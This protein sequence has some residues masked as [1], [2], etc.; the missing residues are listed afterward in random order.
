MRLSLLFLICIF[1]LPTYEAH[2]GPEMSRRKDLP[3]LAR[4]QF[5]LDARDA[6]GR[7]PDCQLRN[8]TFSDNALYL[9]GKYEIS[10]DPQGYRVIC[11]TP[12]LN[13]AA[14]TVA[15]RFKA[16]EFDSGRS[17]I[18]A[19]GEAYRW[20]VINRTGDG[21]LNIILN[22][23]RFRHEIKGA[24]INE[25]EWTVVACG[26]D[27]VLGKLT[28]YLN[29]VKVAEVELPRRFRFEVEDSVFA[30]T[31]KA[32]TFTNYSNGTVFHGLMDEMIIYERML[33]EE[34]FAGIP[35]YP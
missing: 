14:F 7:N 23:Y 19:G 34:E 26:V 11:S 22:N 21:N 16:E 3:V 18:I 8:A 10:R 9:N 25:G 29:K 27:V 17:N 31:D 24:R 32:W 30:K 1:G 13:Y 28:V 12:S 20:I 4:Y 33:S 5:D 35:L 15:V 6:T 2:H